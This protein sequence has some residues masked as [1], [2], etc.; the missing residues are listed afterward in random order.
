MCSGHASNF[1]M[2][3]LILN[4]DLGESEPFELTELIMSLIDAANIG[5]GVHAGSADKTLETIHLAN[6]RGRLIGAHPGLPSDG[7]RGDQIPSAYEFARLLDEQVNCFIDLAHQARAEVSYIKLHGTL[8]H[9]VERDAE[10]CQTYLNFVQKHAHELAIFSLAEG[11]VAQRAKH[12]GLKV[13]QE[14]FV[15]RAYLPD[16]SLLPRSEKGAVLNAKQ[17]ID[18]FKIWHLNGY[19]LA[20]NHSK[21]A[22]NAD[23]LCVHGDSAQAL[24]TIQ[25]VRDLLFS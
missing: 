7:G 23:T 22:L 25:A 19:L 6:E 18:R 17:S 3:Q 13:Y 4:S 16:G 14:A 2:D 24:E 20:E 11:R 21:L 1:L 8:Y 12:F 15:D 9:A 10:L 5:C